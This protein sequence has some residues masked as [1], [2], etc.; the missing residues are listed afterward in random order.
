MAWVFEIQGFQIAAECHHH[1][2]LQ[3]NEVVTAYA[4]RTQDDMPAIE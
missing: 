4:R 3:S 1:L 2:G